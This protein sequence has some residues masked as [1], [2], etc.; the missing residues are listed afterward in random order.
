MDTPVGRWF[1]RAFMT[2]WSWIMMVTEGGYV[3][4]TISKVKEWTVHKGK[5]IL[6][7]I[8]GGTGSGISQAV[9]ATRWSGRRRP[10]F[11]EKEAKETNCVIVFDWLI[12]L[13]KIFALN[14]SQYTYSVVD[15]SNV[16]LSDRPI[17]PCHKGMREHFVDTGYIIR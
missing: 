10:E 13:G 7:R 2:I 17:D 15:L 9:E 12:M 5:Q 6:T 16:L 11:Q 8:R 4:E 14:M 3:G 1:N